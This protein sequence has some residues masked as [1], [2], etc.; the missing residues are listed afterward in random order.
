MMI[1]EASKN[2]ST[3]ASSVRVAENR[4]PSSRRMPSA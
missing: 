2:A 1:G 4:I 3:A